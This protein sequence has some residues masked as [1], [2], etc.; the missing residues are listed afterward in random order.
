MIIRKAIVVA[1]P[2]AIAFRVFCE[3]IGRWWPLKEGYSA[4]GDRAKEI[5]LEDHVGG[6]FF[7]RF[8]D[9]TEYELGRV[10]AY[11]PPRLV[12]FSWCSPRWEGPTRVEIRFVQDGDGTRVEL[13]HS[14]WEQGPTMLE[15]GKRF[16][17]G[18]EFVLTRFQLMR[19][20]RTV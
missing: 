2:P 9:G 7:E 8:I 18:W 17:N 6:R 19:M 5:F 16:A 20:D 12:A 13:Q 1:R 4:G 3:E 11:E 14:G 10:T 15:I